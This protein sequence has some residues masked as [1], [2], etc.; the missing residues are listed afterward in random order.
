MFYIPLMIF[1]IV[2]CKEAKKGGKSQ[3][4][5]FII[6][7]YQAVN[8]SVAVAW[9]EMIKDDNEKLE[10]LKRL[11]LE[12]S[13]TKIY[14][15]SEFG[16]LDQLITS[17]KAMRYDQKTMAS[18]EL[19]DQYDSATIQ[20]SYLVTEFAKNNS[21]YDQRPLMKELVNDISEKNNM[22]IIYRV[23]YDNF[24]KE[25]NTYINDYKNVLKAYLPENEL[26]EMPIFELPSDDM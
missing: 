1:G 18:S 19:I 24:V 21:L 4:D 20:V 15:Q 22:I 2:S 16:R 7:Q 25:R 13:Y 12:V 9:N 6:G 3:N 23:H 26:V 11:L 5:Q 14:D 10:L 17:L 8:D